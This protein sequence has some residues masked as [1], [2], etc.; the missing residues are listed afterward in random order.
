MPAQQRYV[1]TPTL[2][3]SRYYLLLLDPDGPTGRDGVERILRG[4]GKCGPEW[5]DRL[6]ASLAAAREP[7]FAV[8]E[9]ELPDAEQ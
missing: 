3:A 1:L 9:I 4:L 2:E 7:W 5:V 8:A 6:G